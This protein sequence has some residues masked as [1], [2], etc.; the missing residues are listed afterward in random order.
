[1]VPLLAFA[2]LVLM[3]L[4]YGFLVGLDAIFGALGIVVIVLFTFCLF[5]PK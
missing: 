1:M 2:L 3:V 5:A 4:H